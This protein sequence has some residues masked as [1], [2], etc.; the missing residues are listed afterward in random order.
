[1]K[2]V[3]DDKSIEIKNWPLAEELFVKWGFDVNQKEIAVNNIHEIAHQL[4]AWGI[5]TEWKF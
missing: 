4:N 1:M 5:K 2:I 3:Q